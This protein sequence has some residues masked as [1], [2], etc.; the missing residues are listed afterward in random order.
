M[1]L[2]RKE[3][4]VTFEIQSLLLASDIF[5]DQPIGTVETGDFLRESIEDLPG[6]MALLAGMIPILLKPAVNDRFVRIQL[7]TELSL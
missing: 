5:G 1:V 3:P 7:R 6:G 2:Q 4:F